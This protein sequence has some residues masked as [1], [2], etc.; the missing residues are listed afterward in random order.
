MSLSKVIAVLKELGF[1]PKIESFE[2][3]L[4]LQKLVFLL[5]LKGIKTGFNYSLYVRGPY[6]P[7]L[8]EELF[9]ERNK[10]KELKT[11]EKLSIK[12]QE[13]IKEFKE[14]FKKLKPSLLE[15]AATYA[16]FAFKLNQDPITATKNLKNLKPFYSE[17][18]IAVGA[19][20]AKELLFKPT[21]KE[22]SEM[23]AEF[24]PWQEASLEAIRN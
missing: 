13:K 4:K 20:K 22:L 3:R 19:S 12:E 23:L 10:L 24:K 8:T 5:Q 11:R 15:I 6:S 7:E 9:K 18:L 2:D 1:K 16:Y 21:E 17:P 14:L